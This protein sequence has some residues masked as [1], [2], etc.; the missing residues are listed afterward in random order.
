M[1]E[2]VAIAHEN[3]LMDEKPTSIDR[4]HGLVNKLETDNSLSL[5]TSEKT[6][7]NGFHNG[8]VTEND[9]YSLES[10]S[11]V[12]DPEFNR[13]INSEDEN[14]WYGLMKH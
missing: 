5:S 6:L 14:S 10:A 1:D 9:I 11:E 8:H 12:T 2:D 13:T 7:E 3:G 4:L